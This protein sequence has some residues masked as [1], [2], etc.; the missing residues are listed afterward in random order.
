MK[1][2][3]SNMNARSSEMKTRLFAPVTMLLLLLFFSACGSDNSTSNGSGAALI[4]VIPGQNPLS[5]STL[6]QLQSVTCSVPGARTRAD[7]YTTSAQGSMNST[8]VLGP[9][10]PG[11]LSGTEYRPYI[12]VSAFKDIIYVNKVLSGATIV[13]YNVTVLFCGATNQQTN[14][15][16]IGPGVSLTNFQVTSMGIIMYEKSNCPTGVVDYAYT[17]INSS[18]YNYNPIETLFYP[19]CN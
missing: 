16:I 9:F 4:P 5:N 10:N 17:G 11:A 6:I 12:G 13:G 14:T 3:L 7:F 1:T 8:K 2:N 15:P 19:Y 18:V